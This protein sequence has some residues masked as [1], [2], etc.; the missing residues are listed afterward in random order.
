MEFNVVSRVTQGA[1]RYQGWPTLTRGEDG[2]LFVGAS[3]HRLAHICPFGKDLMYESRDEGKTWSAPQI[4]NDTFLD[5]RDAGML[6][7][8]EGNLLLT[9][10][11]H[12]PENF[13]AWETDKHAVVGTPLARGMRALWDS[14]PKEELPYGSFTK[15]SHD[16]GRTWSA[17]RPAPVS[18]PHGPC[19]LSD[20]SLFYVGSFVSDGAYENEEEGRIRAY[21]STDEGAT[22]ELLSFLPS[23]DDADGDFFEPHALQLSDGRIVAAVRQDPRTSPKM[24]RLKIF[25]TF[26]E[27]GGKTWGEAKFLDLCGAPPHLMQHS[28]GALILSYSRRADPMGQYVRISRDGGKTWSADTLISPVSPVWDHGYPSTAELS[29]GSLLT[30]YYQRWGSDPYPS[31]L[32]TH[33]DL[34]QVEK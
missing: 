33:W 20:K 18:S 1:F 9:W 29:D 17:P 32:S 5:D 28:S 6:A 3:G 8:G 31:I 30:V 14:L 15:I 13:T 22:W 27:D 24:K 11:N 23:P 4:I 25:I 16:N 21:R 12:S 26:S 34:S 19:L 7:W 2:T 10:F